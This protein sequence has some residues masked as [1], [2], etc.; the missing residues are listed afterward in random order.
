[1]V[2]PIKGGRPEVDQLDPGVP[3]AAEGALGGGAVL[4]GPVARHKQDVLG[5]QVSVGQVVVVQELGG[6]LCYSFNR[7]KVCSRLISRW[8][9]D[10]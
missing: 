5:L 7:V 4:A 6:T 8:Q 2:L 10:S 9:I 1:V 3:H